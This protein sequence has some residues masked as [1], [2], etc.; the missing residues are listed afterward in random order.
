MEK[1]SWL[2][3][4]VEV[5]ESEE[6]M[7][8][9]QGIVN[10]YVTMM[11]QLIQMDPCMAIPCIL[12]HLATTG[13][14]GTRAEVLEMFG[15]WKVFCRTAQRMEVVR[16]KAVSRELRSLP[17]TTQALEDE[18]FGYTIP[19]TDGFIAWW[20]PQIG[21]GAPPFMFSIRVKEGEGLHRYPHMG[22]Y[23]DEHATDDEEE[24][25]KEEEKEF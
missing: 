19:E 7:S 16:G 10:M 17:M 2:A 13:P 5:E 22:A 25:G 3:T 12:E 8:D 6:G 4:E 20:A 24:P 15:G 21:E 9:Q 11:L 23:T 14:F 18:Q 1:Q